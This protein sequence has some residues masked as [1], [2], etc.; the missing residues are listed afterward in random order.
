MA[1]PPLILFRTECGADSGYGHFFRALALAQAFRARGARA[2]I[3]GDWPDF[4]PRT[5][6]GPDHLPMTG[7]PAPADWR[8]PAFADL[9]EAAALIATDSYAIDA[10]W[11]ARAPAPVLAVTDPPHL[12]HRARW[13][14]CPS[15]FEAPSGVG[16]ARLFLA[17][18]HALLRPAFAAR[19][20]GPRTGARLLIGFGGGALGDR[21]AGDL[22]TALVERMGDRAESLAGTLVLGG[23]ETLVP[24]AAL[25]RAPGIAVR[26]RVADMADLTAAH[27][28]AVG[29]GGAGALERCCLGLAQAILPIADNQRA[30][31]EALAARGAALCQPPDA[32]IAD[33]AAA[34]AGLLGDADRRRSLAEAAYALIDGRG[35]ARVADTVLNDLEDR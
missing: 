21:L 20:A 19:R 15:A 6:D 5:P 33:L 2:V 27:D 35:A 24:D 26:R 4:V 34:V 30:P 9:A 18:D 22:L 29:A 11:H 31:A 8:A 14:L 28:V 10:D 32:G 1:A 3:A 7:R 25:A 23:A 13:L 17:P 12:S 16:D